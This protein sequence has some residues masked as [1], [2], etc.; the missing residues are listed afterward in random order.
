MLYAHAAIDYFDKRLELLSI[1]LIRSACNFSR[2][3][4]GSLDIGAETLNGAR[5][6]EGSKK[7]GNLGKWTVKF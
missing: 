1:K 3:R 4:R 5:A 7:M 2:N 6:G